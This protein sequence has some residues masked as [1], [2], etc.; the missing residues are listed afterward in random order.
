MVF[1]DLDGVVLD[2]EPA[3]SGRSQALARHVSQR[4]YRPRPLRQTAWLR[5]GKEPLPHSTSGQRRLWTLGERRVRLSGPWSP[6]HSTEQMS[7]RLFPASLFAYRLL[8][9][10]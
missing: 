9:G 6:S 2:L 10:A 1:L 7:G 5:S 4:P 3:L 8:I